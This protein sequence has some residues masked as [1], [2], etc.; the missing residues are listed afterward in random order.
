MGRRLTQATSFLSNSCLASNSAC[1]RFLSVVSAR[2]RF[3][4]S[5]WL[6]TIPDPIQQGCIISHPFHIDGRFGT[7][8]E[9]QLQLELFGQPMPETFTDST[10]LTAEHSSDSPATA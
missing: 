4:L 1:S 10:G 3:W 5:T 6:S 8:Q 2:T 7:L 9:K